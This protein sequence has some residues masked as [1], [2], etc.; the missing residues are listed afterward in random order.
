MSFVQK[1]DSEMKRCI[2]VVLAV[3]TAGT[4]MAREETDQSPKTVRAIHS[5][6][7][8][9][10]DGR[11]D[12]AVWQ[13][14]GYGDFTQNDPQDGAP[15]SEKTTV[16][17]AYDGNNLYVAAQLDDS[18]PDKIV[19]LLGRRDDGLES[20]W[21]VFAVDPYLDRRSGY[22]FCVNPAGSIIDASLSNDS[23][24]DDTWD[25]V[26]ESAAR[27]NERGWMV[28]MRIPFDQLRFK[29]QD[30]YSWGITFSR[31]IKRKNEKCSYAWTP[32]GES[33][34]VSHFARLEGIRGIRAG[35]QLEIMPYAL[36]GAF[37][38]PQE[39]GNPFQ[40]GSDL[41]ANAGLDAKLA[42]QSNLILDLTVNPDFGQVEADPAEVNLSA[43]ETYYSEK[44]PFFIEGSSIFSNFGY[45]GSSSNYGF[46][47]GTPDLFYSRRVG[48]SPRG[49][50][51]S[52]GWVDTPESTTIL[53][54]AKLTGKIGSWN[55]AALDALTSREQAEIDLG[56]D[57]FRQDVE[58]FSQYSVIRAQK[59]F[60]QGR[61]GLGFMTT[62]VLRNENEEMSELLP[63]R[64]FSFGMD[65]WLQLG[66]KQDWALTGWW[67]GSLV[68][69]E[70]ASI[71]ALQ[72]SSLHY[73]QR[74]DADHLHYDPAATSLSGWGGRLSL[75]KQ[76][77]NVFFNAAIGA[78]S[79]G[80]ELNDLGYQ[81]NSDIVNGHVL[82]GY[83]WL[84]PGKLFR[85][86]TVRLAVYHSGDFGGHRIAQG[87]YAFLNGTLLNYWGGS[88]SVSASPDTLSKTMTRGG[89]LMENPASWNCSGS[90]WSD[91]RRAVELSLSAG[92]SRD[93][94]GEQN[95]ELYP[96]LTWKP[97]PNVKLSVGPTV[98][99]YRITAQWVSNIEDE[100]MT[101]TY[102]SRYVFARMNEKVLGA[103]IRLS[104][105]FTPRLS[106]QIY[107][108]PYLA[109]GH[110]RE[111]KELAQPRTFAFNVYGESGSLISLADGLYT[112]DP[113]GEGSKAAFS[114]ADPDFNYKS[115]RGTAVLRWE[116]RPG[117]ALYLVWTQ[118]RSDSANPG[119]MK[120]WRDLGDMLT[121]PGSNAVML[122]AS[123]RFKI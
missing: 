2:I 66:P 98:Y 48:R 14:P 102:G 61:Q 76:R 62:G 59:E 75:N 29:S 41:H 96:S 47:F 109:A 1:G 8:V 67:I 97:R 80:L 39:A 92:Y 94:T 85:S 25:G 44:R 42:L 116:Y 117:S 45:G 46:N 26:W 34:Y 10:I 6:T 24:E 93:R 107:L 115:L 16:W 100:S 64:A 105:V 72:R 108:Q 31:I 119:E 88:L 11:L 20:D 70:S 95:I 69:G 49:S 73:F 122:K 113:G 51:E 13:T 53:A 43:F 35:R 55:V 123:Y 77:G 65:G 17:V 54:A 114:F 4:V 91:S 81:W 90:V 110:Y 106:L 120:L 89:P 32:K 60:S 99:N 52:D 27:T 30:A 112:V 12:D 84:K 101:A 28:E 104:W 58:P 3:L 40:P 23:W 9:K 37:F 19:R 18:Q 79:P 71:D 74:P 118:D 83:R 63:R 56:G 22:K 21:F 78:L 7:P 15:A 86:A 36:S 38:S 5:E 103:E 111:F 50:V 87:Y 57:R 82:A 33:G 68:S 121:A